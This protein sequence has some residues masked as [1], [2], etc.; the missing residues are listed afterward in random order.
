MSLAPI[1]H[2]REAA[3]PLRPSF[4][5]SRLLAA[6]EGAEGRRRAR[7]RDQ[8]PDTVGLDAKRCLLQAVVREDP[9]AS[10]FVDWLLRYARGVADPAHR[11]AVGAMAHAVH[12]DWQWAHRMPEFSRWLD[13]GAPSDDATTRDP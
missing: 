7:K 1:E 4:V 13:R 3:A 2:N 5:C 12:E 9:P 6:L 11:S 10:E 8:T